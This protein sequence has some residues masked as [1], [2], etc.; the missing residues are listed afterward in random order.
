MSSNTTTKQRPY[1]PHKMSTKEL[2]KQ[3]INCH[4]TPFQKTLTPDGDLEGVIAYG[5]PGIGKTA[6]MAAAAKEIAKAN[7]YNMVKYDANIEPTPE[8]NRND[9]DS[10][11]A[12]KKAM[13]EYKP[14]CI[15]VHMSMAGMTSGRIAGYPTTAAPLQTASDEKKKEFISRQVIPTVWRTASKFPAAIYLFDEITHVI[16]Q[17]SMLSLLSEGFYEETK[18]S[19]RTLF[20]ATANEGQADDTLPVKLSSAFRNRFT[21]YYIKGN[22]SDWAKDYGNKHAHPAALAFAKLNPQPFEEFQKAEDSICNMPSLRG[23]TKLSEALTYFEAQ[24]LRR[25]NDDGTIN[26]KGELQSEK[27]TESL[28]NVLTNL[29]YGRLGRTKLAQDFV[30]LYSV[31]QA[32]VIP[33]ITAGLRK[34]IKDDTP[35]F[36]KDSKLAKSLD[37]KNHDTRGVKEEG[38]NAYKE[39]MTYK[40]MA[41]AAAEY[42]PRIT[43][44]TWKGFSTGDIKIKGS[45]QTPDK[46]DKKFMDTYEEVSKV[47]VFNMIRMLADLPPSLRGVSINV[48]LELVNS[49]EYK[50]HSME[51][52]PNA[53]TKGEHSIKPLVLTASILSHFSSTKEHPKFVQMLADFKTEQEAVNSLKM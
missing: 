12:Y 21:S 27:L 28:K 47:L 41:F 23:L 13:A 2:M 3:I 10:D 33:Q 32:E 30:D 35:M 52:F 34:P 38:G 4:G 26:P 17:E 8:P 15:F 16:A 42:I 14:D 31:A 11:A 6:S 53:D 50:R 19:Q 39:A 37:E 45:D 5:P 43:L 46:N 40:Q 48:F 18:L 20:I 7:G 22:V 1:E 51:W 9:F 29:A 49:D 25:R 24:N 44:E 36:K